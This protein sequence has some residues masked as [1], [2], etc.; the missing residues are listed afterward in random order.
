MRLSLVLQSVQVNILDGAAIINMLQPGT[1]K[2]FQ[3]YATH[4]FVPYIT[5]Q[6]QYVSRLDIV[7]DVYVPKSLKADTHSK[8]GKGLRDMLSHQVQFLETGRNFFVSTITRPNYSPSGKMCDRHW[9]QQAGCVLSTNCQD[10]SG[11]SPCT[12]EEADT[13]IQHMYS[14]WRMLYGMGTAEGQYAQLTRM[15]WF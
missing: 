2:T 4:V 1:V 14:T 5:S 7:W 6:L 12:Y 3:N 9:H 11:M 8:R 15:L 13:R 10:V